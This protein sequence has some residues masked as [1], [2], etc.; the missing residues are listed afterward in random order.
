MV[1][2]FPS[3]ARWFSAL[4]KEASCNKNASLWNGSLRYLCP[5]NGQDRR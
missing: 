5:E 1:S 3:A 2:V 4:L